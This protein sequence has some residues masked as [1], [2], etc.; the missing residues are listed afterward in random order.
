MAVQ[1]AAGVV[2][3]LAAAAELAGD[4]RPSLPTVLLWTLVGIA[5]MC[6]ALVEAA[7]GHREAATTEP[8]DDDVVTTEPPA[9]RWQPRF[10]AGLL[11]AATGFWADRG[12]D[13]DAYAS[14]L[15]AQQLEQ[16]GDQ[17]GALAWH[18]WAASHGHPAALVHYERLARSRG[19]DEAADE[20][21]AALPDLVAKVR[22]AA[23]SGD[24]LMAYCMGQYE[25]SFGSAADAAEW[26]R[27]SVAGGFRYAPHLLASCLVQ[28]G[29]TAEATGAA[30]QAITYYQR[31]AATADD[32]EA[33]FRYGTALVRLGQD[34]E[35]VRWLRTAMN[36]GYR[37]AA[38]N[39]AS[40]LEKT[41]DEEAARQLYLLG[42]A[43]GD[44]AAAADIGRLLLDEGNT[45]E[46]KRY[47]TIAADDGD[48]TG[49]FLL[50]QL[51]QGEGDASAA[52]ARYR[53]AAAA[54]PEALLMA[55]GSYWD[56]EMPA[57]AVEALNAAAE[58]ADRKIAF[59]ARSLLAVVGAEAGDSAAAL[60]WLGRA[61][62]MGTEPE[63]AELRRS[64]ARIAAERTTSAGG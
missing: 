12:R 39:L 28:L 45:P 3:L 11:A 17:P 7:R 52:A 5:A 32:G 55:A 9:G 29:R 50:A 21:R 54:Y 1:L 42:A 37:R 36:R 14:F 47:L 18:G 2:C 31:A 43:Q 46:A 60:A 51:L 49:A 22:V 23:R 53:A 58:Q 40:L 59:D 6:L 56:A 10:D 8:I 4:D 19:A 15:V 64:L 61:A 25:L 33:A 27:A 62:E 63:L 24:P 16:S 20:A 35:A 26:L 38:T 57:E 48:P 34:E 30:L 41:G 13:G 44:P